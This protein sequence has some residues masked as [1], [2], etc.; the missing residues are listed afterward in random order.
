MAIFSNWQLSEALRGYDMPL[1]NVVVMNE[2]VC[3]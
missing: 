3:M 1:G 2:C